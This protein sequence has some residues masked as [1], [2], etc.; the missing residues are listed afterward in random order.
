ML[1]FAVEK[2]LTQGNFTIL[3]YNDI[4]SILFR[5]TAL[6]WLAIALLCLTISSEEPT[7]IGLCDKAVII[8]LKQLV[9]RVFT[10]LNTVPLF[11]D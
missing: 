9:D 2:A 6:V 7:F 8:V 3:S 10:R 11:P 5:V 1:Q 4:N